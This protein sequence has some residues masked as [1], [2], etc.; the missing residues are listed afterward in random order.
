MP[1]PHPSLLPFAGPVLCQEMISLLLHMRAHTPTHLLGAFPTA[2][3]LSPCGWGLGLYSS[4]G[5]S[6]GNQW[7]PL[8]IS[9]HSPH[10]VWDLPPRLLLLQGDALT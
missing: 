6:I 3:T 2:F 8:I 4:E 1:P 7:V 10:C 5:C 9:C